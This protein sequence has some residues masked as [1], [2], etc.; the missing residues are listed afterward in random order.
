MPLSLFDYYL[1]K[2]LISQQPIKPRDSAR[3]LILDR[4]NKTTAHRH[5]FDLFDY[6]EPGDA[7]V[8]NNSKVI[9]ARLLGHR[10]TGGRIEIFLLKKEL[11]SF[12]RGGQEETGKATGYKIN[13]KTQLNLDRGKREA[14]LWQCLIGGKA[15]VGDKIYFAKNIIGQIVKKS[16][17]QNLIRFD[18]SDKKLFSIGQTPLPPYIKK[19]A[20]LADYQTI[21]AK[22]AGSVAAP[23]AGLHFTKSLLKK[24]KQ[25]GIKI[26]YLTLHVGLGTFQPVKTKYINDH[27]IHSEFASLDE[28]TAREL[29]QIKRSGKKIIAVGTTTVRTLEAASDQ[30]GLLKPQSR[31]VNIFIYP[32]YKFKFVDK[33]ITNFHLPK[34]TLIMLVSAFAG[35]KLVKSTYREAIDKKYRFFSFGD[36]MLII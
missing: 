7:L 15:K 11:S 32:G 4:K 3:L 27:K 14:A 28:K 19:T 34:S 6:L 1:P 24:L 20:R 26:Y 10:E 25:K 2:N 18:V 17:G 31:W 13:F 36:A 9:P 12:L 5:F 35:E 16:A 30:R 22:A 33:L 23:T 21:Y 8:L 29:N